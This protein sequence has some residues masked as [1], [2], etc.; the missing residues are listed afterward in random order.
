VTWAE[1]WNRETSIYVNDRHRR[2][3]YEGI[4]R[5]IL[6][7]VPGPGARVVDYGCGD[8]LSADRVA[9]AC[10]QLLLCESAP[11]VRARLAARYAGSANISVIDPLGFAGLDPRSIDT[12]I[13]NSVVQYLSA[14]DLGKLLG[15]AREKLTGGGRLV[16]G[17]IVPRQV[18]PVRDALELFRFAA[19]NGFLIAAAIGLVRSSLSSY[20]RL[21]RELGFLQ[22]DE[23]DVL[24]ALEQA[25]LAGRRDY[26]NIG[27]N[28][29]RTTFVATPLPGATAP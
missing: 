20:P 19:A 11:M 7:Y 28:R 27:H 23:A 10:G 9:A 17:D 15:L 18:S 22:L 13:V 5:D 3:H 29:A 25:G 2:V 12:I 24:R 6:K 4:A 8:T 1:F 14:A 16:L 26:P 21:R